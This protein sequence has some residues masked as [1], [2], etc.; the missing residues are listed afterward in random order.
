VTA[1]CKRIYLAKV[2]IR[3]R[4]CRSVFAQP[5]PIAEL[6]TLALKVSLCRVIRPAIAT[7]DKQSMHLPIFSVQEHSAALPTGVIYRVAARC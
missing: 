5:R 7:A 1:F 6:Q 2:A 4:F 3:Q